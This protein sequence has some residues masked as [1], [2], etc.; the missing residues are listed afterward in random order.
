ME[1]LIFFFVLSIL[2]SFLCSIWEAVLL[3]ITPSYVQ[4]KV[5][6][7]SPIGI[8][9]EKYK[10]DID[11]PLS[12]ILTL[13]TIAHTVGAIGVGVQAKVAF[14][15]DSISF[16]GLFDLHMESLIATLM[17]LAILILSEIIPKTIGANSWQ[18]LA[19]FTVR[20]LGVL[21]FVLTPFVWISQFITKRFKNDKNKSVLSRAD[22]AAMA[23]AGAEL[24]TLDSKE[25]TIIQN[26]LHLE[27]MT[28]RDVMTPRTV[29]VMAEQELTVKAFYEQKKP[30]RYSRIPIYDE[31]SDNITGLV[32]MDDLLA[33]LADDKDDTTLR[34]IKRD[35]LAIQDNR[36]LFDLFETL[37]R[38]RSHLAVVMDNY[39]SLVGLITLEDIIET[40]FGLE[41]MDESDKV[42]DLQGHAKRIW[43]ERVKGQS[44][45]K[46]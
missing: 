29:M 21:L 11:R 14:P 7:G 39:G 34:E 36:S 30:H 1:L 46:D 37:T 33:Q 4:R 2:F 32:L 23:Q 6:E 31:S 28:A 25:F 20:S 43:E 35:V 40:L 17:T 42:A 12:A 10:E 16:F 3:S 24:G 44:T 19:P 9:L 22:F 26:L 15:M 13:N 27:Q 45:K 18:Q 41:I 5:Q 38:K 8:A